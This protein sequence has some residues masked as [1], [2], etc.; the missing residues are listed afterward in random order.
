MKKQG[1]EKIKV[2]LPLHT[3]GVLRRYNKNE[4]KLYTSVLGFV[5]D[6]IR[7]K[8]KELNYPVERYMTP[9]EQ[10]G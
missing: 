10:L 2:G 6:A 7:D 8:L 3:T 1:F 9:M 5:H 4:T